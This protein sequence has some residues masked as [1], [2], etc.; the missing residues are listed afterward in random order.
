MNCNVVI[1]FF[2]YYDDVETAV[3]ADVVDV[4]VFLP[5]YADDDEDHGREVEAESAEECKDFASYISGKPKT[6]QTPSD[7]KL[8]AH[9]LAVPEKIF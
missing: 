2:C 8:M 4:A 5:V 7:L 3:V 6:K 1:V 9:T